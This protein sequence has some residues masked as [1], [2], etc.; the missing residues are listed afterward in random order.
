[1]AFWAEQVRYRLCK[2]R[3]RDVAVCIPPK[4]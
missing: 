3:E 1:L 4:E 2:E